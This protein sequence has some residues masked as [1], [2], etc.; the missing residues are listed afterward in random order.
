MPCPDALAD[1]FL[2]TAQAPR[3]TAHLQLKLYRQPVPD[4][5]L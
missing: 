4:G 3:T 1:G 2:P 5:L